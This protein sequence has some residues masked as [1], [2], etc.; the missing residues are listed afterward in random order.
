MVY[1]A[2]FWFA[3]YAKCTLQMPKYVE[4]CDW[5]I[6]HNDFYLKF[7]QFRIIKQ[8]LM[9][10]P[11]KSFIF[12]NPMYSIFLPVSIFPYGKYEIPR[13]LDQWSI[14][15]NDLSTIVPR[16]CFLLIVSPFFSF[17]SNI[18]KF[19]FLRNRNRILYCVCTPFFFTFRLVHFALQGPEYLALFYAHAM[20]EIQ[21]FVIFGYLA[22]NY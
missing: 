16:E 21:M 2:V 18:H 1:L 5:D 8:Q 3:T 13:T 22:C 17:F 19:G 4:K 9:S 15:I 20:S 11:C 14:A 10:K 12:T 6:C 7:K